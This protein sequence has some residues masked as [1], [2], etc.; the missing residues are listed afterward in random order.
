[1]LYE[2]NQDRL[3]LCALCDNRINKAHV[4][5]EKHLADMEKYRFEEWFITL[6]QM[7]ERQY[8]ID[9][10][11]FTLLRGGTLAVTS[12]KPTTKLTQTDKNSIIALNKKGYGRIRIAKTL[13]L[14]KYAVDKFLNRYKR[15][16]RKVQTVQQV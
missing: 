1:M 3:K 4:V 6:C 14:S 5:C 8:Q 13:S 16:L 2:Q 11:E 7:Q 9:L 12:A 15:S 10:D